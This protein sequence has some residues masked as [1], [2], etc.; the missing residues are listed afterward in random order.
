VLKELGIPVY[1]LHDAEPTSWEVQAIPQALDRFTMGDCRRHSA[2]LHN[3]CSG[4]TRGG[5]HANQA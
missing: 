4:T 5:W 3:C 2:L 1:G